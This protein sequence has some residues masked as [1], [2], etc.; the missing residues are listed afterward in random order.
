MYL[1]AF[2]VGV[3]ATLFAELATMFLWA[4]VATFKRGKR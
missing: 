1:N 3:F 4:V 2:W